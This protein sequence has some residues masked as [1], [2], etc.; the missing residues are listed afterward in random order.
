MIPEIDF[1]SQNMS[2]MI[3]V[4]RLSCKKKVKTVL[5]ASIYFI[6]FRIHLCTVYSAQNSIVRWFSSPKTDI[7][8]EM[9]SPIRASK[10]FV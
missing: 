3:N 4:F 5:L 2:V 9:G 8:L 7:I 10:C 6:F 1:E